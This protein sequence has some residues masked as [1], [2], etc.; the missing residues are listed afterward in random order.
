MD[1]VP[2]DNEEDRDECLSPQLRLTQRIESKA[3][4]DKQKKRIRKRS[5]WKTTTFYA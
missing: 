1:T 2:S 3:L 4:E 5:A